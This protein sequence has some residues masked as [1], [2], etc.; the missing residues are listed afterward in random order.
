MRIIV[1]PAK[2]MMQEPAEAPSVPV[3]IR[4]AGKIRQYLLSLDDDRF[5][6]VMACSRK[7]TEENRERYRNMDLSRNLTPAAEAYDGI[8][9]KYL[10]WRS[11]NADQQA[12]LNDHLRILSA[13]YGV[14]KPSDGIAPYRLEM[15]AKTDIDGGNMY[16]YWGRRIYEEVS[17]GT[18]II[19]LASKEYEK[20]VA[21]YDKNMIRIVFA[22]S[23]GGRLVS[24]GAYAK[25][26]R[27]AM[28]R[29]MAVHQIEDPAQIRSFSLMDYRFSGEASSGREFVF[30]MNQ[31]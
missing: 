10:D 7:L 26:A 2:T 19:S 29:W 8:Q 20:C 1:S 12:Y 28:V 5:A 6:Q 24:R 3:F 14:L 15:A 22:Q 31:E 17:D 18:V 23:A 25:M 27:G 4:D 9:Y 13:F 11:L 21:P 16:A 30:V